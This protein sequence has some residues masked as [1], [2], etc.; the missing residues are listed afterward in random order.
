MALEITTLEQQ[1]EAR[2]KTGPP[3][4]ADRPLFLAGDGETIVE[5]GDK[6]ARFRFTSPGHAIALPDATRHGLTL[7]GGKIVLRGAPRAE[8]PPAPP[9]TPPAPINPPEGEEG[10]EKEADQPADKMLR[11]REDKGRRRV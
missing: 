4:I 2:K 9:P 5:E 6:R 1:E 3:L 11:K 8:E 7:E 10:G